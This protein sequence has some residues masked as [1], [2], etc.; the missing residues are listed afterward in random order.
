MAQQEIQP[1]GSAKLV[2]FTAAASGMASGKHECPGTAEPPCLVAT[3]ENGA[4]GGITDEENSKMQVWWNKAM[5]DEM[6]IPEGYQNVAVLII[7]WIEELDEL[8]TGAE[9]SEPALISMRATLHVHRSKTFTIYS[10]I[11]I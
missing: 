5:C 10:K 3:P 2:N 8:K 4:V 1:R 9:V 6:E 11:S 7:K